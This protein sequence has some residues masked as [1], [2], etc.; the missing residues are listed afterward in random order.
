MNASVSPRHTETQVRDIFTRGVRWA[1]GWCKGH[2]RI[3]TS[4][5][6]R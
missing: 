3:L 6:F 5:D 1:P 4:G 2:L